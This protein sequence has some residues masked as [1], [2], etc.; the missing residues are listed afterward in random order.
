MAKDAQR[1]LSLC[2]LAATMLESKSDLKLPAALKI[3]EFIVSDASAEDVKSWP[4]WSHS[5]LTAGTH[6]WPHTWS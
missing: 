1:G 5:R 3:I 2:L 4:S 6:P